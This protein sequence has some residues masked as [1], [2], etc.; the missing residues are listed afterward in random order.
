MCLFHVP[1]FI[2]AILLEM[3]TCILTVNDAI[4]DMSTVGLQVII[5]VTTY[6][7]GLRVSLKLLR[8]NYYLVVSLVVLCFG[9]VCLV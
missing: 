9:W 2:H 6:D 7:F 4:P 1:C 5:F 3:F 8:M